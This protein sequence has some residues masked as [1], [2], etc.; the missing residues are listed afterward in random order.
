MENPFLLIRE[1][2]YKRIYTG[3]FMDSEW[4]P[5]LTN[6]AYLV[7]FSTKLKMPL[8]ITITKVNCITFHSFIVRRYW[9]F[10]KE[11]WEHNFTLVKVVFQINEIY[12]YFRLWII[13]FF[14][15]AIEPG[16]I[17][18]TNVVIRQ[19]SGIRT[20]ITNVIRVSTVML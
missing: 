9:L 15:K 2:L 6:G 17:V 8:A 12:E 16:S 7:W 11:R 3:N 4:M 5:F 14:P 1:N 19:I 18:L 10:F 13:I 20:V